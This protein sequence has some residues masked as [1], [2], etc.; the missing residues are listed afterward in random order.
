[1]V[2]GADTD[3]GPPAPSTMPANDAPVESIGAAKPVGDE[4]AAGKNDGAGA[5][6]KQGVAKEEKG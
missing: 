6:G 3:S 4:A 1:M 5:Q 2:T